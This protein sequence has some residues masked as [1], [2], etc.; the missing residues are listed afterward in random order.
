M[1]NAQEALTDPDSSAM[2]TL[3]TFPSQNTFCATL[4][5]AYSDPA[6]ELPAP[7]VLPD[8]E[9]CRA[10]ISGIAEYAHCLVDRPERCRH[11]LSF[12]FGFLC[13]NP[14]RQEIIART[15]PQNGY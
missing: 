3:P 6:R 1:P 15:S 12:G 8:P 14:Q 11:A 13:I 9:L 5:R 4:S 10:R 2:A 7:R